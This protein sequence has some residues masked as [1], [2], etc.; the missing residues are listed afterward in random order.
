MKKVTVGETKTEIL[1]QVSNMSIDI[2]INM[3]S[4]DN[5]SEVKIVFPVILFSRSF[6]LIL[7]FV[8]L[9]FSSSSLI[10]FSWYTPEANLV[11]QLEYNSCYYLQL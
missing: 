1:L 11:F 7:Y 6:L 2:G 8:F 5:F 9:L 4:D 10:V 3:L